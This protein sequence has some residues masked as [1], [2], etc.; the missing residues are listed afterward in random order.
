[1]TALR[2]ADG[3]TLVLQSPDAPALTWLVQ[4][5]DPAPGTAAQPQAFAVALPGRGAGSQP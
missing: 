2:H 1:V 5:A 3:W 4:F